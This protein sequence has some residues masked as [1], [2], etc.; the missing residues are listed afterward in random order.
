VPLFYQ[1]GPDGLPREWI[2][3]MKG[4]IRTICPFFNTNRMVEEYAERM[5][6]PAAIQHALLSAGTTRAPAPSPPGRR[7]SRSGGTRCGW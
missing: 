6:L 1:R 3:V 4:S 7:A 2:K 5:Y